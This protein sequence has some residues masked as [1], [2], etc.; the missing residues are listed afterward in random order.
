MRYETIMHDAEKM[1]LDDIAEIAQQK[2]NQLSNEVENARNF[3]N[4]HA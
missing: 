1:G 3:W 4:L 2:L